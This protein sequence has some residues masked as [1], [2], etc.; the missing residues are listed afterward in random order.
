VIEVNLSPS[1]RAGNAQHL[2][3]LS[4][5]N[6]KMMFIALLIW[7]VPEPILIDMWN[8][9]IKSHNV[10]YQK[11]NTE[12]KRLQKEVRKM[13][14]V[15]KQVDALKEQEQ[16]L[17]RKLETVKKIINKRQNPFLVLRYIAENIPKNVW[18]ESVEL[19]DR[20]LTLKGYAKK[21]Q[22][23]GSFITSLKSSIFFQTVDYGK[24]D[25]M[26]DTIKGERLEAF[27][28]TTN[29]VRFK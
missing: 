18:L 19:N 17:A 12:F 1:K 28:I 16:K 8:D 10:Q 24:P 21:Y 9:E 14:N 20:S 23:L 7:F 11:L 4:L 26:P 25:G 22:D 15:Q 29:V 3:L 5:V 2:E 27:Q 6:V 13:Q